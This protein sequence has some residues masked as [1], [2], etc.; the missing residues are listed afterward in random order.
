MPRFGVN[1]RIGAGEMNQ[2]NMFREQYILVQGSREVVFDFLEG[3]V[4]EDI[5]RPVEI[6]KGKTICGVYLHIANTYMG[7]IG[8]FGMGEGVE[9]YDEELNLNM[10]GLRSVLE[11]IDTMM[12]RFFDRYD[13]GPFEV[14]KGYPWPEKYLETRACDL[15][16]HVITH[17]FHHKGQ[18]MSMARI[19]GHVPPDTDVIRT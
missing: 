12:L 6:F 1:T 7:W 18:A 5:H 3:R 13:A 17:E 16:T 4:G 14:V 2:E 11:K 10:E 8:K 19:L 15:F 9:Y